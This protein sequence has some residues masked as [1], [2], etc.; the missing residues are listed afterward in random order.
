MKSVSP[1]NTSLL[2]QSQEDNLQSSLE[3]LSTPEEFSKFFSTIPTQNNSY[4][5]KF[6]QVLSIKAVEGNPVGL[7]ELLK[8]LK[9]RFIENE[10]YVFLKKREFFNYL[11]QDPEKSFNSLGLN[12]DI[13]DFYLKMFNQW[14]VNPDFLNVLKYYKKIDVHS[15]EIANRILS[16]GHPEMLLWLSSV[17]PEKMKNPYFARG[18]LEVMS[19]EKVNALSL[20]QNEKPMS[21]SLAE[22]PWIKDSFPSAKPYYHN[23][24]LFVNISATNFEK[25]LEVDDIS[26]VYG[27]TN[28]ALKR[29]MYKDHKHLVVYDKKEY[30]HLDF[31]YFEVVQNF[32]LQDPSLDQ[33]LFVPFVEKAMERREMSKMFTDLCVILRCFQNIRK[34]VNLFSESFDYSVYFKN[35][36]LE[37]EFVHDTAYMLQK[38]LTSYF[39]RTSQQSKPAWVCGRISKHNLNTLKKL[40]NWLSQVVKGGSDVELDQDDISWISGKKVLGMEVYVPQFS[41][42]LDACGRDLGICVGNGSYTRKVLNKEVNIVFLKKNNRVV[43]CVEFAGDEIVQCKGRSNKLPPVGVRQSLSWVIRTRG[44]SS[45]PAQLAAFMFFQGS[46]P[47][48]FAIAFVSLF[49]L[50]SYFI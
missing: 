42:E 13:K 29:V 37:Y 34:H 32:F 49:L 39:Y 36:H 5:Q 45:L 31:K 1:F 2:F 33:Q 7:V 43:Y 22:L 41:N 50:A 16:L 40:H 28:R 12:V 9:V 27:I 20:R 4:W 38:V 35:L 19:E 15:E 48:Y 26:S 6:V 30:T 17:Y 18:V 21:L 47:V 3:K 44:K 14:I 8:V 25:V 46:A 10:V 11:E 23:P 24:T